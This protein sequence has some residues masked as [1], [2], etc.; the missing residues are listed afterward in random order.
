MDI[1]RL[2]SGKFAINAL[3]LGLSVLVYN[4][5]RWMGQNGLLGSKSPNRSKAE[6]A[7]QNR[8]TGTDARCC[9]YH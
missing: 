2:P 1:E 5:L 8:D 7:D 9:T 3:V 4:I 6:A